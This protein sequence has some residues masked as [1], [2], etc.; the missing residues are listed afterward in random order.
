MEDVSV[1]AITIGVGVILALITISAVFTYYN[2]AK[3]AVRDLGFATDIAGLY[4][5]SIRDILLKDTIRGNDVKNI[6]NYFSL[7]PSVT[8]YLSNSKI[9]E[10]NGI[11]NTTYSGNDYEKVIKCILPNTEYE[12]VTS[13]NYQTITITGIN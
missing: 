10:G 2:T 7:E 6:L 12:L 8:I 5:K 3:Q 9:L 13:N 1:R 4:E 11:I